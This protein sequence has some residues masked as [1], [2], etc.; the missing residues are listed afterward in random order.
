MPPT[1][2]EWVV[3]L[4]ASRLFPA[5]VF[6]H[7]LCI[8]VEEGRRREH[9][10]TPTKTPSQPTEE[11]FPLRFQMLLRFIVFLALSAT[12]FNL[13]PAA[14]LPESVTVEKFSG[15]DIAADHVPEFSDSDELDFINEFNARVAEL[16]AIERLE[17]L[18]PSPEE[19]MEPGPSFEPF[20]IALEREEE[21]LV[22]SPEEDMMP[23]SEP[24]MISMSRNEIP[25]ESPEE[26]E[27][28]AEPM[29]GFVSERMDEP[30]ES[31]DMGLPSP[32]PEE[33]VM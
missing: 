19:E 21:E 24:D 5:S 20:L 31:P 15:E 4:T 28:S 22:A 11:L 30:M 14:V 26:M 13:H 25:M 12:L 27:A 33:L 1:I 17:E 16:G 6:F 23:S 18:S 10:A 9:P 2:L 7:S 8:K 29:L 32:E 3:S